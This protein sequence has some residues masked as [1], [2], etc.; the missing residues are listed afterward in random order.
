VD[1]DRRRHPRTAWPQ[2][3]WCQAQETSIYAQIGNVSEGGLFVRTPSP[4]PEGVRA[5]LH[6]PLVG[7]GEERVVEAVV[8][9]CADER[10][11]GLRFESPPPGF[12]DDL[13][14]LLRA[15]R[16]Q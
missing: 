15:L 12:A 2:R 14:D 3:C 16:N 11:M 6:L 4:L 7:D 13:C 5:T 1:S 8:V 10:G 9:W